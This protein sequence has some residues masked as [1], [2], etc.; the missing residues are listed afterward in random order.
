MISLI[1]YLFLQDTAPIK[2]FVYL[3]FNVTCFRI[4]IPPL[5]LQLSG[6]HV[7]Q[8]DEIFYQDTFSFKILLRSRLS[9]I[10]F[11]VFPVSG[12]RFHH[13]A[14]RYP[15]FMYL[16]LMKSCIGIP[17]P[18]KC[19]P[20]KALVYLLFSVSCF[21]IPILPLHPSK[22]DICVTE[23]EKKNNSVR[24]KPH[25]DR[26]GFND[27]FNDPRGSDRFYLTVIQAL[28]NIPLRRIR[29]HCPLS[30]PCGA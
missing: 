1:G 20:I 27:C 21:R 4:P 7:S 14:C 30:K 28:R 5:L 15:A 16:D 24:K 13:Y 2:A 23:N 25:P 12:Y 10:F 17:F 9:C 19:C 18:S 26:C 8:F 11:S 3:L 22:P 6:F 29:G